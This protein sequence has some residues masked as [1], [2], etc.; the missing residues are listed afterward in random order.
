[1]ASTPSA[2]T[3]LTTSGGVDKTGLAVNVQVSTPVTTLRSI[4]QP[5]VPRPGT[6]T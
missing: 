4:V 1:V 3:H 2:E 5:A 6:A